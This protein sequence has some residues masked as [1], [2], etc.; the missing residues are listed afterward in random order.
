MSGTRESS[1]AAAG[2]RSRLAADLRK[3]L[4]GR[5]GLDQR[6]TGAGSSLSEGERERIGVWPRKRSQS[7]ARGRAH[8]PC[9]PWGRVTDAISPW[10]TRSGRASHHQV[11]SLA[12]EGRRQLSR[13]RKGCDDTNKCN[14]AQPE[15]SLRVAMP[16]HPRTFPGMRRKRPAW[17]ENSASKE[18]DAGG[19]TADS[20]VVMENGVPPLSPPA[21]S[22]VLRELEERDDSQGMGQR[23]G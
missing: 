15:E 1:R 11:K 20:G 2:G 14:A 8:A 23:C 19:G 7:R 12:A 16:G 3:S 17:P 10:S 6:T 21:R 18:H 5:P 9:G 4:P 13:G 22:G